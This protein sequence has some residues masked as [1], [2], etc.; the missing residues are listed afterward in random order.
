[1]NIRDNTLEETTKDVKVIDRLVTVVCATH[2]DVIQVGQ[3]YIVKNIIARDYVA[4]VPVNEVELFRNSLKPPFRVVAETDVLQEADAF[5]LFER[6]KTLKQNGRYGWYLQ[7]FVKMEAIRRA[8][9]ECELVLIWDA[10]TVPLKPLTFIDEK[11]GKLLYYRGNEY[12]KPYFGQIQR[13][14]GM[15]R[16][17]NFS[18]IAQCFV[19][20]PAWVQE[21]ADFIESRQSGTPSKTYLM[22]IVDSIYFEKSASAFSE[23]EFMGTYFMHTRRNKMKILCNRWERFGNSMLRGLANLTP[24]K[25]DELSLTFDHMTFENWDRW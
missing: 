23:Y 11:D 12:H 13:L 24:Q 16:A 2:L 22:H 4:Y 17:E 19:A 25:A 7:Q 5:Y 10:D 8:H 15:S 6:L 18:F 20:R 1:M 9:H 3:D 21:L 14:L